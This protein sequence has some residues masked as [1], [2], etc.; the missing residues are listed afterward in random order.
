MELPQAF[1][2][3]T[4]RKALSSV[5][6][7]SD[8]GVTLEPEVIHAMHRCA[9]CFAA[10]VTSEAVGHVTR[11]V[12]EEG[13]GGGGGLGGGKKPNSAS[14]DGQDLIAAL[15]TLGFDDYRPLL[16][17]YHRKLRHRQENAI[18]VAEFLDRVGGGG[19]RDRDDGGGDGEGE[20]G[21]ASSDDKEKERTTKSSKKHQPSAK[22]SKLQASSSTTTQRPKIRGRRSAY[23]YFT[24]Q[25]NPTV[26]TANPGIS[27]A[28]T[29]RRLADMWKA[30]PLEER[31]PFMELSALDKIRYEREKKA[32]EEAVV[33]IK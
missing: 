27:F 6:P 11:K 28:D 18:D 33:E 15:D 7:S 22:R 14:L 29:S 25:M 12:A 32:A 21:A 30:L 2:V 3:S 20:A 13:G 1:V 5:C 26:A 16:R 10:L 23:I 17:S 31:R 8:E 19:K 9:N 4:I 24:T